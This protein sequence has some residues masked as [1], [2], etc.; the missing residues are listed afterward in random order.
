MSKNTSVPHNLDSWVKTLDKLK[1]PADEHCLNEALRA[2]NDS[3]SSLREIAEHFLHCPT[4]ALAL[5]RAANQ[6][7]Y[8]PTTSLEG[9]LTRLGISRTEQLLRHTSSQTPENTPRALQQLLQISRHASVQADGLFAQRLARLAQEIHCGSLLFLAPLWPLAYGF[10]DLVLQWEQRVLIKNEPAHRVEKELLGT[11]IRSICLRL[12]ERWQLPEWIIQGY[13]L[14][15]SDRRFLV[16]ALS[17][18]REQYTPLEQQQRLDQDTSLRRWLTQ[19]SNTLLLA[20]V[21]AIAAHRNWSD[22]HMLRWQR[23]NALY[24]QTPLEQVQQT[25][26][27]SAVRNAR[28]QQNSLWHPA[29]ALLWPTG[30]A[31]LRLAKI[32]PAPSDLDSW[33][34]CC[35][36]LVQSPSPF[37]NALQLL[38]CSA[39][40]LRACGIARFALLVPD[41]QRLQL[42]AR[43]VHGLDQHLLNQSLPLSQSLVLRKLMEAPNQLRLTPDN[44]ARF[45]AMLAAPIKEAF[46]SNHL[47]LQS[48]GS[49]EKAALLLIADMDGAPFH[50]QQLQALSKTMQCTAHA[51]LR[52]SER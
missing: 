16:K 35:S 4:L 5:I 2:L 33:R 14:L 46:V 23:L 20:N 25:I 10:P 13:R 31:H 3:S 44:M 42:Q 41:R 51:L 18:S 50:E 30:Q 19:P 24:L 7:V 32:K 29:C 26:H 39:Q 6:S 15:G 45:S 49:K 17:L 22:E 34:Q 40:A 21:I 47:V 11:S 27:Q 8:E 36:Q 9:A 43:Q 1:L 48:I 28:L 12:A 38:N 37:A 52:F